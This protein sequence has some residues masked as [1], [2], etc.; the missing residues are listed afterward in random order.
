MMSEPGYVQLDYSQ[1]RTERDISVVAFS[2]T[3]DG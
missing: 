2:P 1:S 3:S